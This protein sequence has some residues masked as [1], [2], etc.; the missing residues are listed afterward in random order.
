MASIKDIRVRKS[1]EF[2]DKWEVLGGGEKIVTQSHARAREIA[3]ARRRVLIK[4]TLRSIGIQKV[5]KSLN[6]QA[7]TAL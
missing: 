6:K 2:R 4:R 7:K 1:K 3:G 5:P